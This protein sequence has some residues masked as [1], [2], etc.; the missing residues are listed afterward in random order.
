M[1]SSHELHVISNGEQDP[2]K[3]VSVV[4]AIHPHIHAFH[5]RE[6]RWSA[7]KI[8]SAVE[9]LLELGVPAHKLYINDR[10]DIAMSYTLGGVQLGAESLNPLL[11]RAV[12]AGKLR[13]GRS[14]HT[15]E[16][17][18]AAYGHKAD[19][20]LYGHVYPT[21]SK[22]GLPGRG[23]SALAEVCSKSRI[24]VIAIGGITP[25]CVKEIVQ[26]GASGIAIMSG[27]MNAADPA[28]AAK[29]YR[30]ALDQAAA[31][32]F[33]GTAALIMKE[34]EPSWADGK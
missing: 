33:N 5:L 32:M 15:I 28:S 24:P 30:C 22:D 26:A 9:Q 19:Y 34:S 23:I 6:R 4:D 13:I 10:L 3:L 1:S 7:R 21:S 20:I 27:I 18:S 17:S 11:A 31:A 29:A 16:E 12:S 8:S 14:V 25:N 2:S